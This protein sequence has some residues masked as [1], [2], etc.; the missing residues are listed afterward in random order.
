MS[1]VFE[2]CWAQHQTWTVESSSTSHHP[3]RGTA[4][5]L[6]RVPGSPPTEP[7]L[8]LVITS[9]GPV[10]QACLKKGPLPPSR[11][12]GARRASRSA[13]MASPARPRHGRGG[14][15][16]GR[17]ELAVAPLRP[18]ATG[19]Y[20]RDHPARGLCRH[21]GGGSQ[22]R[23]RRRGD[24]HPRA[25]DTGLPPAHGP[26]PRGGDRP[27]SG[28]L[29]R[30]GSVAISLSALFS[31]RSATYATPFSSGH[32]S[33]RN[34]SQTGSCPSGSARPVPREFRA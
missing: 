20:R 27:P 22:I 16:R 19:R 30:V 28:R 5:A 29:A 11:P 32:T 18:G 25:R 1:E 7:T 34:S 10:V 4:S 26:C 14:Q 33:R 15:R 21:P 8:L 31:T 2:Q 6:Q 12:A 24:G 3:L 9:A 13:W 17:P 23:P